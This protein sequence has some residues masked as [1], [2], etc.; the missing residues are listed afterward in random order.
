[1]ASVLTFERIRLRDEL[2]VFSESIFSDLE[3]DIPKN[4]SDR[5]AIRSDWEKIGSDIQKPINYYETDKSKSRTAE[6]VAVGGS[7]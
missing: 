7:K 4:R 1:M 2:D 6:S 3:F 5:E